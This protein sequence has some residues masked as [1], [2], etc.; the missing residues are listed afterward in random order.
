[1]T[2]KTHITDYLEF[3]ARTTPDKLALV[4]DDREIKWGELNQESQNA[5][6]VLATH[7]GA[8][9]EQQIIALL[10]E[11][12]WEFVVAYLAI[13]KNGHI[14]MPLDPSYKKLEIDAILKQ[15]PPR[16]IITNKTGKQIVGDR[17]APVILDEQLFAPAPET[18][19]KS[20]RLSADK[21]IATLVFTS[22]TTGKPKASTY[23]H[24]NHLWNI[25]ACSKVWKW[26]HEDSLLISLPLSHWYGL[27]MGLSGIIYH[28]NMLYLQRWF[29]EE[30]TLKD[31]S[32]GKITIY[33]AISTAYLK[34]LEQPGEYNLDK[35]RLC[36][37]GGAALP[38]AIWQA[39]SD[40]FGV[41]ILECYGS[42]E[43]G[44][45]ASNLLDERIPGS[46][47]RPLSEVKIKFS[48]EDEVLIKSPGIFPGYYKN[49]NLTKKN[50]DKDGWWHTGDLGKLVDGRIVLRGR[51]QE[52][53]RKL[54]YTISP[55]DVEWAMH[56]NPDIKDI[57]VMGI[58]RE[59][60]PNDEL[61][62]FIKTT[63]SEEEINKYCKENLL[64]AWRPDRIILLG[65]IPRT[66]NGKPNLSKLKA[67]VND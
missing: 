30:A 50:Y 54:G 42:S 15:I 29:D 14:A 22:G 36:I 28:G 5:A 62:Y 46:P 4:T 17:G 18:T 65:S 58:Q 13:L 34:L 1:M 21:Q 55:R 43:T 61:T 6:A 57:F 33:T 39:F 25:A 60:Q 23:S 31:L 3:Y 56:Q 9:K 45:I 59:G 32:G 40:R 11:N 41:Q 38:P 19:F 48:K 47:G 27:A 12:C 66:K 35:V 44:R 7:L 49:D 67:L 51:I 16:L 53:I 2:Q 8:T 10:F 26:D 20:L 24:A 63:L 37:S 52:R 64:Y